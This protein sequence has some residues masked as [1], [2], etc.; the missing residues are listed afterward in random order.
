MAWSGISSIVGLLKCRIL[1][2]YCT[3]FTI[4]DTFS[5]PFPSPLR[6]NDVLE[7]VQTT[8]HFRLLADAAEVGGAGSASL[9]ALVKEI[10][11]KYT[12]AMADFFSQVSNVLSIDGT[13]SFEN[14]F[15]TFRTVVKVRVLMRSLSLVCLMSQNKDISGVV[16]CLT[17]T[18]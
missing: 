13:Q 2:L 14:A 11:Q 18:L 15:F 10:H 16:V 8:R 1:R 9:D 6:C 3:G 4:Q 7:L 5:L 12:S 17:V